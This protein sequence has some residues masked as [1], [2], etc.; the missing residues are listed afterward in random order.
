M[1]PDGTDVEFQTNIY[2]PANSR[3]DPGGSNQANSISCRTARV[4]ACPCAVTH[5][6]PNAATFPDVGASS[7][8]VSANHSIGGPP[9]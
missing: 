6:D 9:R 1:R 3:A 8:Y 2:G 7:S 5:L 4:D